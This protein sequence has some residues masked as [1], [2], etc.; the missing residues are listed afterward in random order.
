MTATLGISRLCPARTH[1]GST[2]TNCT[3]S[4]PP[5]E[6]HTAQ[7]LCSWRDGRCPTERG[8][9]KYICIYIYILYIYIH[10]SYIIIILW[11]AAS[12]FLTLVRDGLCTPC[13]DWPCSIRV[14]VVPGAGLEAIACAGQPSW[15]HSLFKATHGCGSKK[16]YQNGTLVN[17]TKA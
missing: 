17:G 5:C 8:A 6:L 14:D 9:N 4:S 10:I 16:W 11:G 13:R 2:S 1:T 15:P 12:A 3:G 7:A